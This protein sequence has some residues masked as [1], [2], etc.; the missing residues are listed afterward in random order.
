MFLL[1]SF[2]LIYYTFL[3]ILSKISFLYKISGEE[4]LGITIIKRLFRLYTK[5]GVNN[6]LKSLTDNRKK[7]EIPLKDIFNLI[8]IGSIVKMQSFLTLDLVTTGVCCSVMQP[9]QYARKS[10]L[11][12]FFRCGRK[13]IGLVISSYGLHCSTLQPS[14]DDTLIRNLSKNMESQELFNINAS[15]IKKSNEYVKNPVIDRRCGIMDGTY[16]SKYMK[17][18]FI[19]PGETDLIAGFNT[20]VKLGKELVS[21]DDLIKKLALS[22]GNNSFDL[23]LGDGLYYSNKIFNACK[24]YLGAKLLVKTKEKIALYRD[25]QFYIKSNTNTEV[26][27]GF[28]DERL[29][30]YKITVVKSMKAATIDDEVQYAYIEIN[31]SKRKKNQY[32][33]YSVITNDLQLT[34]KD[35]YNAA[36][37]RW[38]I[39]NNGFRALNGQFKTKK[40]VVNNE[41]CF[42]RMQSRAICEANDQTNLLWI[43]SIAYNVYNLLFHKLDKERLFKTEKRTK[44]SLSQKIY[45]SII[46]CYTNK[47]LVTSN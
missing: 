32:V 14:S 31:Y 15:I 5:L 9:D 29:C 38:R 23:I 43:I 2:V 11:K 16:M 33:S 6:Y 13:M 35:L 12:N 4:K 20:I 19:I 3:M 40:R 36:F 25:A 17:E 21:A 46:L 24:D 1:D 18:F 34:P 26:V 8:F 10:Y 7:C 30:S 39:E 22:Y 41:T 47:T 44:I 28:D 37:I 27:S 45:D 42:T